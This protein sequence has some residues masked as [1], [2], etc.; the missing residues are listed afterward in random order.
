MEVRHVP[1][2]LEVEEVRGETSGESKQ[3]VK[4]KRQKEKMK[5]EQGRTDKADKWKE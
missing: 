1:L 5:K 2:V 4:V 3:G